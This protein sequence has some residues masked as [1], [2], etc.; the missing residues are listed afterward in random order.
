MSRFRKYL[1]VYIAAAL[2]VLGVVGQAEAQKRNE[3][4]IRDI[5]RSLNSRLDDFRY[6]LDYQL[7][8][9][10][11]SRRTVDDAASGLRNLKEKIG[12]F[13]ANLSA[14][15]ENR[16]DINQIVTAAQDIEGFLRGNPQNRGIENDWSGVKDLINRLAAYYNVSPNWTGRVSAARPPTGRV[17]RPTPGNSFSSGLSGSYRLDPAR[18]ENADQIV[19]E[20]NVGAAQ[21]QDLKQKLDAPA[22]LS[23][24]VR[25]NEVTLASSNAR[26]ITFIADGREKTERDAA[27]RTIK[28]KATLRGDQ[29]T[30]S[31]IGGET[32]YTVTF[33]S[34]DNGRNLK[35]TRRITTDYLDQTVFADSVYTKTGSSDVADDDD[36]GS[37]TGNS[38]TYS[39]N[40]PNDRNVPYGNAPASAPGRTGDF[41][42]PNGTIVTAQLESTI[43][44]KVSQNNDRFKM[45]VQSPNEFRGATITG[46]ISGVGRS[47]RV[48]GSS[49]VTFN[50]ESITLRD[51][52]TYDFAG[53]LQGIKDQNGKTV[54][55]DSEGTARGD[56][57]TNETAKRGGIGAGLGAIIGAIAGGGKGAA[58]GAII[59]GGAGAGSVVAQGRDDV[60]LMQGSMVTIQASSPLRRDEPVSEN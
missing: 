9:S 11:A 36:A 50:F 39:S 47:G 5:V 27:G 13:D 33:L 8:S 12:Q 28:V 55:V 51:G 25:G 45:T 52:R 56:S 57:Q 59:G 60:Q 14:R 29:L 49:N 4:D 1:S 32:D 43:D 21:R 40:D 30:V 46:Y 22:Q 17:S 26:P 23:I 53:F 2:L 15:R 35:V 18:S 19:S 48:S 42:V 10:S 38:G 54:K 34:Q 20:S 44:T 37:D 24:D 3:R 16:D 7:T 58:I 31:S 6:N 41:V